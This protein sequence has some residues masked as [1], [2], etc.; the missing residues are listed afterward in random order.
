MRARMRLVSL[1]C[2]IS[3]IALAEPPDAGCAE[4]TPAPQW[5]QRTYFT[6]SLP[7]PDR[8]EVWSLQLDGG[9]ATLGFE[10][11][12]QPKREPQWRCVQASAQAGTMKKK[13]QGL[14]LTFEEFT[15]RCRHATLQVAPVGARRVDLPPLEEDCPR[16][17]WETARRVAVRALICQ[18]PLAPGD[19]PVF[20]KTFTFAAPPGLERLVVDADDCGPRDLVFAPLRRA[21][22][23]D[24]VLPG[25]ID[26]LKH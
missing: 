19:D 23:D 8:V 12:E 11:R 16:H 17:R 9:V 26:P 2:L 6:S 18:T 14:E 7:G 22:A 4:V 25:H 10:R 21:A 15:L 3:V 20:Q 24:G 1:P 5:V 13:G